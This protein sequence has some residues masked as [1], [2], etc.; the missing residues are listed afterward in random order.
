M[1][2][3][4]SKRD[5]LVCELSKYRRH[6]F[7]LDSTARSLSPP[8]GPSLDGGFLCLRSDGRLAERGHGVDGTSDFLAIDEAGSSDSAV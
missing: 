1:V 7:D 3:E 4:V 8:P 6:D 5:G 2:G